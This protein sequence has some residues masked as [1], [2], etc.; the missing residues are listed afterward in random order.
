MTLTIHLAPEI[1]TRLSAEAARRGQH[2]TEFVT[3]LLERELKPKEFDLKAFLA[4][5][6]NE[7]DMLLEAAAVDAAPLYNADLT[8]PADQR[9]LTALTALD[10]EGFAEYE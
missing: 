10:G 4:M 8:L 2:P 3:Q 1:E 5:S 6:L 7:Q 9:E